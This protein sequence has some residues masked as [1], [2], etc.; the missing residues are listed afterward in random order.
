M[1]SVA[2]DHKSSV[3]TTLEIA[4]ER[5]GVDISITHTDWENTAIMEDA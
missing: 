2:L 3:V 4:D 5:S 1:L